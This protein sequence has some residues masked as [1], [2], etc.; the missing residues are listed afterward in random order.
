MHARTSVLAAL[1]LPK[2]EESAAADL[3]ASYTAL[4]IPVLPMEGARTYAPGISTGAVAVFRAFSTRSPV[5][6]AGRRRPPA[7]RSEIISVFKT[8]NITIYFL[9]FGARVRLPAGAW[10]NGMSRSSVA[11]VS[12][13][14]PAADRDFLDLFILMKF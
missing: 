11:S 13:S 12:G 10:L 4:G 14:N 7:Q 2:H 6:F 8:Y 3:T 5:A 9:L 1:P